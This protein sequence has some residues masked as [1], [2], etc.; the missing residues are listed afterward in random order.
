[1]FFSSISYILLETTMLITDVVA[2]FMYLFYYTLAWGIEVKYIL[3]EMLFYW[4][5]EDGGET[6]V[7]WSDNY[8]GGRAALLFSLLYAIKM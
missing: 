1:M 3:S 8:G 4:S 5:D 7:S 2:S 6:S